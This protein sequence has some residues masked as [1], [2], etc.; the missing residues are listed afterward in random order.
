MTF[1]KVQQIIDKSDKL[2]SI[3]IQRK[4]I[5]EQLEADLT[6]G[7]NGG[8]F[9]VSEALISFIQVL[10]D[11]K[12]THNVVLLDKNNNPI[13]IENLETFQEELID[14]YLTSV[15]KYHALYDEMSKT[16]NQQRDEM[17]RSVIDRMNDE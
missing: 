14:R 6:I 3:N 12:K 2:L 13:M 8:M 4:I 11:K 7:I 17:L 16:H 1:E 10:I 9:A 5:K 15:S